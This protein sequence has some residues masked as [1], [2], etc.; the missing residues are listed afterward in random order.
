MGF[1]RPWCLGLGAFYKQTHGSMQKLGA[2]GRISFFIVLSILSFFAM[3]TG[4]SPKSRRIA[5]SSHP[6][7]TAEDLAEVRL[8][9]AGAE[10]AWWR[11]C[12]HGMASLA[13]RRRDLG[14][15]RLGGSSGEHEPKGARQLWGQIVW[16]FASFVLVFLYEVAGICYQE[17]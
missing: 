13:D 3:L 16:W 9:A 17:S 2:F 15:W 14:L 6:P 11:P 8:T 7:R 1:G 4:A 10:V 5:S 12:L